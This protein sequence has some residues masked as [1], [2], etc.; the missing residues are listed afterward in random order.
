MSS[1]GSPR[2]SSRGKSPASQKAALSR[3]A[4]GR[5]TFIQPTSFGRVDPQIVRKRVLTIALVG[6]IAVTLAIVAG[7]L[8][9][10]Q[11]AR[12]AL[13]PAVDMQEL[14][15]VLT[16]VG[17]EDEVFWAVV[18]H[19]DVSSAEEGRGALTDLCL[20]CVDTDNV[21][22]SC[23]WI[24]VNTRVYIDGTGY[25]SIE[26]AF[27]ST[28]DL[29]V[30]AAIKKLASIDVAYYF[31][32]NRAGLARLDNQLS[33]GTVNNGENRNVVLESLCRK[34][35]GSSSEQISGNAEALMSCVTTNAT[36]AQ[37]TQTIKLLHGINMETSFFIEEMPTTL[38]D[39][40]G[41]T[42]SICSTDTWNTMV[43]RVSS[44]M[45]PVSSPTEVDINNT[46]RENCTVSVWNGVGVSGVANDCTKEL[47]KLGWKVIST[48]NAAQFVYDETF[49]VFKDT[50]DEAAA[51]LLAAD[52]GQGRVVRSY[53]RYNYKG[54]LLVVI[55][56][57]YKPY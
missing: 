55:G 51:R 29:G 22:L 31:E 20:M 37:F 18:A 36:I 57:D 11:A 30:I 27:E 28:K 39:I 7:V 41:R 25:S 24:P 14:E 12:N 4:K 2:F 47:E 52:L 32:I 15:K 56:K 43:S 40:D 23:F 34:L 8:V 10:Q 44:G 1:L 38:Q 6:V 48:G 45:S 33:L 17:S 21:M 42:Y 35:F 16:P 54:N 46:T 19:T 13:K 3:A 5:G 49:V 9:Y 53:A 50:D 26:G